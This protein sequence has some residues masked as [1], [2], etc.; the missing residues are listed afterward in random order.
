M[1]FSGAFTPEMSPMFW[2][3]IMKEYVKYSTRDR[4]LSKKME[5]VSNID[6]DQIISTYV[7]I[8]KWSGS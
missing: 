4:Y 8:S 1:L 7:H 2:G 3:H 5:I 6:D